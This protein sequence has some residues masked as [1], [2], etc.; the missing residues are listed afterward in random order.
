MGGWIEGWEVGKTPAM[1]AVAGLNLLI[2][3]TNRHW[4]N[5]LAIAMY[6]TAFVPYSVTA[7]CSLTGNAHALLP[8]L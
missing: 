3:M 7:G 2:Q 6:H 5:E 1:N 4:K 8:V